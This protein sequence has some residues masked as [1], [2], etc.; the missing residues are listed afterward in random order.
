[1][2]RGELVE[3]GRPAEVF[4][5]PEHPYTRALIAAIPVIT[6]AEEAAKP[7][8][9]LEEKQRFLVSSAT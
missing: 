3:Q 7:V 8:V 1:M 9:T 4:A 5:N 2:L 6:D